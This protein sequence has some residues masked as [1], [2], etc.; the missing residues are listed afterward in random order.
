MS[1]FASHGRYRGARVGALSLF[2]FFALLSAR[3]TIQAQSSKTASEMRPTGAT[4]GGK[5]RDADGKTATG[6]VVFLARTHQVPGAAGAMTETT[7]TQR[8][9]ADT[10]GAYS[11]LG[12]SEGKYLLHA[13]KGDL[14]TSAITVTLAADETKTIDIPLRP[15]TAAQVP[16]FFDQ[17][18]FT[19]AGVTE[20]SNSGGHGSDTLVKTSDALVKATRSLGEPAR[21]ADSEIQP[22]AAALT[23]QRNEL[24]AQITAGAKLRNDKLIDDEARREQAQLHRKLAVVH[25]ALGDPVAAVNEYQTAAKLDPSETHFFDWACE[26]LRHRA[27]EPSTQVFAQGAQKYPQSARM[28]IGLGVAW[29]SRGADERASHYLTLASDLRPD[30]PTPYLFLG[31]MQSAQTVPSKESVDRLARFVR[32]RPENAWANYYYAVGLWK[33]AASALDDETSAQVETLLQKA[34]RLDPKLGM[35]ELQLG[36]VYTRRGDLEKARAAYQQAVAVTPDLE[37]A[38]YRLALAYRRT[39]DEDSARKEMQIYEDLEKKNKEKAEHERHEI[40]QFVISLRD[41]KPD[42]APH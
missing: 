9:H 39:G 3:N 17:P 31:K 41:A 19:V 30:D 25:E 20:A 5:V 32:L 7:E 26:L 16:D 14:K 22:D 38:H 35:A 33:R 21:S 36:A 37:E 18:Q 4:L 23:Q 12:L 6:V 34:V 28:L 24:L 42:G 40:Q 13:E 11:F 8:A 1:Q 2:F 10:K 29:L 27:F 15:A